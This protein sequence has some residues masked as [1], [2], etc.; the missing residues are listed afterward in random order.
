[1]LDYQRIQQHQLQRVQKT[2]PARGAQVLVLGF[3]LII[4]IGTALLSLPGA[5]ET[6]G[7]LH[8][9]EALFTAVSAT[10]VTGL[11]VVGTA[12]AF[13]LFGEIVILLLIQVGG[14]GFITLSVVLFRLI[15]RRVSIYDRVL[16]TRT[17]GVT[18]PA[19][20]V[21]LTL[22]V[23]AITVGIEIVGALILFTQWVQIMDW[24]QAV[25]YSIFH[26]ISAFCNAGFDLFEGMDD[27]LLLA[28]RS[29]PVIVL[30]LSLLITIGTLG[31]PVIYDILVWPQD[32]YLS[33]LTRLVLGLTIF[34]IVLG[35]ILLM[36]DET[37]GGGTALLI[38]P[39]EQRWLMALFTV[40]SSRTA[41]LTF[42]RMGDLGQA[43][44]FVLL[45][46]MFIGAAPAS[47]G[48][49]VGLSSI[50][51]VLVT[52]ASAVRGHSVARAFG[53][54]LPMETIFKAVAILTLSI[55]LIATIT[56][57][58]MLLTR[59]ADIF[60]IAFEVVSA[61]SNTGY[62]LGI[63]N[64]FDLAAKLLLAFTMF[65]GRLGP[66]TL[67]VALTQRSRRTFIQYPEEKIIIG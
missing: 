38:F 33:V 16:L 9:Y 44:Q 26:A 39:T 47:M 4:L 11:T 28:S 66:L 46:S 13:S 50:A 34:L 55:I 63:T 61:F 22:T 29:N 37:L 30:N 10:T 27:P 8:W 41:G 25:H 6:P 58:L 62:S 24:P 59:D 60:V 20:I 2:S 35:T 31:I 21:R 17:L 42:I 12:P 56:L 23:L 57:V 65:W 1:M 64:N 45:L 3:A 53:R 40:V 48:G 19:G 5:T 51:V 15:G 18:D 14:V 7:S 54:T 32:R 49:G 36:V 67:V 52:L 43:S